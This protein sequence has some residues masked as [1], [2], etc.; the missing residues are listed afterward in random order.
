[1]VKRLPGKCKALSLTPVLPN[2]TH[3]ETDGV[4]NISPQKLNKLKTKDKNK[5]II[6]PKG[7]KTRKSVVR[8]NT[9]VFSNLKKTS[10][11]KQ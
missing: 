5:F 11:L 4:T 1:V 7:R 10:F 9:Y 2:K 3:R 8:M 6:K